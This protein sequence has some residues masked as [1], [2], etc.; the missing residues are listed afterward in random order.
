MSDNDLSAAEPFEHIVDLPL[1]LEKIILEQRSHILYVNDVQPAAT[2]SVLLGKL[3]PEYAFPS[4]ATAEAIRISKLRL[5]RGV[6]ALPNPIADLEK[7]GLAEPVAI[8]RL[9]PPL[10]HNDGTS[11]AVHF[12]EAAGARST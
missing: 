9:V 1:T 3:Y 6:P 5:P 11:I 10:E 12:Q 2:D 8:T 4:D 7:S